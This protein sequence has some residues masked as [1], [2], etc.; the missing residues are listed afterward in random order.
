MGLPAIP[1]SQIH[2][3]SEDK[4]R[5]RDSRS[6]HTSI[7]EQG[8][9]PFPQ[10]LPVRKAQDLSGTH[11]E[12]RTRIRNNAFP[13]PSALPST[14]P[15]PLQPEPQE[16]HRQQTLLLPRSPTE[17]EMLPGEDET[18]P[19]IAALK[20]LGLRDH[21]PEPQTIL[22]R[23]SDLED[24]L[25]RIEVFVQDLAE[26]ERPDDDDAQ[27][28]EATNTVK[29][30]WK[31]NRRGKPARSS[32]A[33]SK[34]DTKDVRTISEEVAIRIREARDEITCQLDIIATTFETCYTWSD[35][36]EVDSEEP[37][38]GAVIWQWLGEVEPAVALLEKDLTNVDRAGVELG[39][40]L[41]RQ[42]FR[43]HVGTLTRLSTQLIG[44][45]LE[46]WQV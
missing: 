10:S 3:G 18:A 7:D 9:V 25:V 4:H 31:V 2:Q 27:Q 24:A 42:A 15:H 19:L 5:S 6:P 34:P 44:G 22:K 16:H 29:E 46:G 17:P 21:A 35:P 26:R 41:N 13:S 23:I 43:E 32:R 14:L 45:A 1:A 36:A 11:D 8:G 12:S 28:A 40:Q 38:L 33:S 20:G 30:K 39:T 37:P